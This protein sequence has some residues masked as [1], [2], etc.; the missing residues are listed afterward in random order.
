MSSQFLLVSMLQIRPFLHS[1]KRCK[2]SRFQLGLFRRRCEPETPVCS[3]GIG[4]SQRGMVSVASRRSRSSP[5]ETPRARL[6][7]RVRCPPFSLT[8]YICIRI[9]PFQLSSTPNH[10]SLRSP[11]ITS[12]LTFL[13]FSP[14]HLILVSLA[15]AGPREAAG[16]VSYLKKRAGPASKEL[17]TAEEA[18]ALKVALSFSPSLSLSLSRSFSPSLPLSP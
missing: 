8:T 3:T 12:H 1:P 2:C 6:N 5:T 11:K 7:T 14:L 4:R 10:P 13:D 17:T 16:I 9:C 18:K 15:L